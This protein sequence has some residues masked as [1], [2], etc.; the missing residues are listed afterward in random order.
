M[1]Q[2]DADDEPVHVFRPDEYGPTDRGLWIPER[3]WHGLS[4][5]GSAYELRLLPL[6]DGSTD[7]VFLSS[8]QVEDLIEELSFV[9]QLVEDPLVHSQIRALLSLST[10][11]SEGASKDMLGIEFP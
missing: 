4:W 6:L 3:I 9:E 8:T 11:R 2:P 1:W 5:L 7:P 10:G